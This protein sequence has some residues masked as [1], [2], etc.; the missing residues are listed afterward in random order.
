M[1]DALRS[2]RRLYWR[3]RLRLF[4]T[5]KLFLA[6]GFSQIA[7][8]FEAAEYSY[9]GPGCLI[10][11]GVSIGRY[12]ML[13][14][15]VCIVGNDHVFDKVGLPVIFSGRPEFKRTD[16]GRDVWVGAGAIIMCGV[17]IGDGA[18][19]AA[20]SVVTKDVEPFAIVAGVPARKIRDRFDSHD[21][22]VAHQVFLNG[23]AVSRSFCARR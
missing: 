15:R 7:R 17:R 4:S 2:F 11:S 5:S 18:I 13:G 22:K 10:M 6:G 12:T 8:D 1:K 9:V 23:P 14:P 19:V 16:I 21:K 20:G 3:I